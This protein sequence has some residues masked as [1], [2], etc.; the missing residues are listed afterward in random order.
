MQVYSLQRTLLV[1]PSLLY[2][3]MFPVSMG[4]GMPAFMLCTKQAMGCKQLL[5]SLGCWCQLVTVYL[6]SEWK[7]SGLDPLSVVQ[8]VQDMPATVIHYHTI[9]RRAH[10]NIPRMSLISQWMGRKACQ[11]LEQEDYWEYMGKEPK[12]D[13]MER[14]ADYFQYASETTPAFRRFRPPWCNQHSVKLHM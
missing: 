3:P 13:V 1:V 5:H 11:G 12:E 8:G 6:V 9:H 2:C 4:K 10:H 7:A 14:P